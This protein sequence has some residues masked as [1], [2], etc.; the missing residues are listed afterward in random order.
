MLRLLRRCAPGRGRVCE[1]RIR[2]AGYGPD[3]YAAPLLQSIEEIAARR[4]LCYALALSSP[5]R[6]WMPSTLQ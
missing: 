2:N 6:H 3:G 1:C 5:G 4:P